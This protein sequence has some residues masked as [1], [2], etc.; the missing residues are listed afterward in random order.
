MPFDHTLIALA[1]SR[2]TYVV[3]ST[4]G[5]A[6]LDLRPLGAGREVDVSEDTIYLD[7]VAPLSVRDAMRC[8]PDDP[9]E[10]ERIRQWL[11]AL[12]REVAFILS[13]RSEYELFGGD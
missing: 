13:H 4:L 12:P 3:A 7:A 10:A 1:Q 9:K 8:L 11:V 2:G 5:R 6:W